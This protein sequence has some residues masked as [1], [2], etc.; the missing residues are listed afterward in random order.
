[1][2]CILAIFRCRQGVGD[3]GGCERDTA[4][5]LPSSAGSDFDDQNVLFLRRSSTINHVQGGD[6]GV[7]L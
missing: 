6:A 5:C 1:M 7:A 3:E 4:N 2:H